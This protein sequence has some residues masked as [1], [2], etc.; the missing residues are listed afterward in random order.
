MT[1]L[2][3]QTVARLGPR[4]LPL[5]MG[6]AVLTWLTSRGVLSASRNGSLPWRPELAAQA[7]ELRQ[8]VENLAKPEAD[9]LAQAIDVESRRRLQGFLE[10][11]RAYR[12]HPY[13]RELPEP[14]SLMQIG[15]ARLLDYGTG[16]DGPTVLVVPSLVNRSYILDLIEGRS[17]LRD[18]AQRGLRPL[19]VDWGAP[20]EAERG[21]GLD[22]YIAG[23][24]NRFLDE[25]RHQ[26][27]GPVALLGYCMGGLLALPL[28]QHRPQ[29]VTAL[30]LL[31]TPWDFTRGLEAQRRLM[32]ALMPQIETLVRAAGELPVD[33]LQAMF[34]GIDPWQITAKF[35]AFA[36]M[37]PD[38]LKTQRFVA[39]EDWL[40]DGV[41]LVEQVA[42]TCLRGWYRDNEPARGGWKIDGRTVDPALVRVPTLA[43]IP[44]RDRIVPPDSA[45]A[46]AAAIPGA[47]GR[48]VA[49]G[50]IGMAVG[51]RAAT[52]LY[53]PLTKWLRKQ[54]RSSRLAII[55]PGRTDGSA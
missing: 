9:L 48:T 38:H 10:G 6:T 21:F 50:H 51:A 44:A 27:A 45:Q 36:R 49:A 35:Q 42:L 12:A 28:A 11:V 41:P 18:M 55:R 33:A 16:G 46:L 19:L 32:T 37:N 52:V 2:Q 30:A 29:D 39:L 17:L 47:E 14:P 4:P 54:S 20:G 23:S 5:H 7:E 34:A 15:A 3:R 13:R 24:L 31:A 43:L 53:G 40:N 25:A 26:A 8:R 1:D 22:D